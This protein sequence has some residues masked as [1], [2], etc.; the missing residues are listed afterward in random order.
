M[1]TKKPTPKPASPPGPETFTG[2]QL[3]LFQNFLCNTDEERRHL[4]NTIVFWDGVP[5]YCISRKE[6]TGM[7]T[8][9]GYLPIAEREFQHNGNVFI[10]RIRPARIKD[11]SSGKEKE[12]YPSSREELVEDALRK[13]AADQNCGF[14]DPEP[15][16]PRSGVVFSLHMLRK[17]LAERGHTASYQQVTEALYILAL[18]NIEIVSADGK[19]IVMSPIL[20]SLAIVNKE[21]IQTDPGARWYA[22]FS[23]MVTECIRELRY[24]QYD[25]H[26][27]MQHSSQLARW[28]HKRLSSNYTNASH[29]VPYTI[30]FATVVR[31]SGLLEQQEKRKGIRKLDKA[32]EELQDRSV[33]VAIQKEERR[34]IR[35]QLIDVKYTLKPHP[36]FIAQVKAANKRLSDGRAALDAHRQQKP[37]ARVSK[38]TPRR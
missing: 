17:E 36:K 4:S 29:A 7:R 3:D 2:V 19:C 8:K 9:E 15:L 21:Q 5:K 37:I 26:T 6:M 28:M 18:A 27:M 22:D 35:A 30:M 16:N 33:L 23:P 14:F 34:G 24:R 10:V 12:Y 38:P 32:L 13:I 1:P 11:A 31:D 25:Y 20:P